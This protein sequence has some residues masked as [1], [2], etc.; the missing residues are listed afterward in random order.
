MTE[1][2]KDQRSMIEL[3]KPGNAEDTI[4]VN[5]EDENLMGWQKR[6]VELMKEKDLTGKEALAELRKQDAQEEETDHWTD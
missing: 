4:L 6:A 3:P 1:Q 2:K 5:P